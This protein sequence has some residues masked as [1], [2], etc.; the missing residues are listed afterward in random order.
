[1]RVNEMMDGICSATF[2]L[3]D[4]IPLRTRAGCNRRVQAGTAPATTLSVAYL[5][6]VI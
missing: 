4:S 1:M 3:A 6:G 5:N 2:Y